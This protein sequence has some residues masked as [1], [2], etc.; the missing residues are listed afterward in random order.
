MMSVSIGSRPI[1]FNKPKTGSINS[2]ELTNSCPKYA[3][4]SSQV[5]EGFVFAYSSNF[6]TA[7]F[8][9]NPKADFSFSEAVELETFISVFTYFFTKS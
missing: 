7:G 3:I 5:I 9:L 1:F 4:I 8:V 6:S 2:S